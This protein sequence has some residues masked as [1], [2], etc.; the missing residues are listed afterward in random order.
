MRYT[1]GGIW[2]GQEAQRQQV[3]RQLHALRQLWQALSLS[4]APDES[5]LQVLRDTPE[6]QTVETA[7]RRS[8]EGI[9]TEADRQLLR[10]TLERL[11]RRLQKDLLAAEEQIRRTQTLWILG[12]TL[13]ALLLGVW[14]ALSLVAAQR[15]TQAKLQA[16]RLLL[17]RWARGDWQV[18]LPE[19]EKPLLQP[20]QNLWTTTEKALQSLIAEHTDFELPP[21]ATHPSI[22]LLYKVRQTLQ[23]RWTQES[24]QA[25]TVQSLAAFSEIL[26]ESQTIPPACRTHHLSIVPQLAGAH[27]SAFCTAG[28]GFCL[29]GYL[30]V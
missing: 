10:A 22:E 23:Q 25:L 20:L 15:R 6:G 14:G 24:Q 13:A 18:D 4:E 27:G 29:S 12:I 11:D 8:A 21:S 5:T 1:N 3:F 2:P 28:L 17:G 26:K 19:A 30:C 16:L 7:L 9:D